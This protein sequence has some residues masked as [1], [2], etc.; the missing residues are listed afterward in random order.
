MRLQINWCSVFDRQY[1]GIH[2]ALFGI[3]H[4]SNTR[5]CA[6]NFQKDKKAFLTTEGEK[7]RKKSCNNSVNIGTGKR[8]EWYYRRQR[9]EI[10][11]FR[12]Y[13]CTRV[14]IGVQHTN[15]EILKKNYKIIM[16]LRDV[17]LVSKHFQC[18]RFSISQAKTIK[19][20]CKNQGN[21]KKKWF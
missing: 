3:L 21:F 17:L 20:C 1:W 8:W 10:K 14:Q 13:G 4:C 2:R 16:F 7:H 15:D 12:Y 18:V 11:N 5:F 19:K 6:H 9:K